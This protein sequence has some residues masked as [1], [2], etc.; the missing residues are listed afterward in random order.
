MNDLKTPGLNNPETY[1]LTHNRFN[2]YIVLIFTDL[3]KA[4][5]YKMPYRNGPHQ[6]IEKVMCLDYLHLFGPDENN[7]DG[8]FLFE[9]EKRKYV[10][11]GENLFSFGTN[12][13]IDGYTVEHGFNDV[14]YPFA[15]GK[16]NIYFMLHQ[17]YIPLQEYENST[18]KNEYQYLYKKDRELKG[19]NISVENEGVVEYGNDF[20]NYKIIHSKQLIYLYKCI[21]CRL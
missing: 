9:I 15:H 19:D 16:E 6:E 11:V 18:A 1:L 21:D 14:K 10:H 17:K 7:K 4:Q 13:E 8:N 12:D 20:I 3:K 5:I 2:T